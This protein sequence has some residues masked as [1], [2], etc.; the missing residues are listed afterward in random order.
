MTLNQCKYNEN[1]EFDT[2][3]DFANRSFPPKTVVIITEVI[4][5]SNNFPFCIYFY[6]LVS[7]YK[8]KKVPYF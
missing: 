8:L 3:I 5:L 1:Y 7:E 4:V 6:S 2:K